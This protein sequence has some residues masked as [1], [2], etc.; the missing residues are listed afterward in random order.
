MVLNTMMD[1]VQEKLGYEVLPRNIAWRHVQ[2][3]HDESRKVAVD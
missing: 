2:L 3:Q 1:Y